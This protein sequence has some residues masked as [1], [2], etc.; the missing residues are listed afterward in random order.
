MNLNGYTLKAYKMMETNQGIAYSANI[1]FDGK[2]IGSASN[3]GRGG[4]TDVYVD[5]KYRD[6]HRSVL[7]EDFVERMFTLGDYEDIFKHNLKKNPNLEAMAF[8]FYKDNC[9]L[10]PFMCSKNATL[11][12]LKNNLE[13]RKPECQVESIEIFRSLDDF[14][15][16]Q[17]HQPES[18]QSDDADEDMDEESGM[19]MS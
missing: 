13:R 11:D 2:K 12:G 3:D 1:Y 15:V 8:V 14:N 4:M 5:S 16:D 9:E 17:D 10:H 6:E 7:D 19:N 18:Y